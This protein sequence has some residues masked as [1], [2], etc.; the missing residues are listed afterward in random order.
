MYHLRLIKGKSY[1]GI[2]KASEDKPDVFV[3]EKAK[4]EK[5][6]ST[7]YFLLV[8]EEPA[9]AGL[10]ARNIEAEV[11][12]DGDIFG[13]ESEEEEVGEKPIIIE[14]NAK[15]KAELAEYADKN[16][17]DITGCKTKDDISQKIIE[18]MARAEAARQALRE[19]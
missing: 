16:G 19:G 13:E 9:G 11:I 5:L 18:D 8:D 6:V 7:G 15:T 3:E 4:V 14:L 2:V 1:W 12:D 17:I 10:L